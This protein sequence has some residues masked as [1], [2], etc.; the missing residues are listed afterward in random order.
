MQDKELLVSLLNAETEKDAIIALELQKLLSDPVLRKSRWK[1]LGGMPNNQSIVHAQQS[2]PVAA[3]V[4]KFTNAQDAL[5]LRYCKARGDDPRDPDAPSSMAHAIEQFLGT[6]AQSFASATNDSKAAGILRQYAEDNIVLYA[7]GTKTRPSLSLYDA[8][9]GQLATDFPQTF[10]SLIHG[11]GGGSYK[12]AIPFVQGRFN[13]GSSGVLPFCSEKY[14]MQLIVSRVPSDLVGSDTHEWA[15]TVVCFFPSN[16]DPSWHYLVGEDGQILTAGKDPLGLLPRA[17]AKSGEVSLPREKEVSFGTLVKMYDFK[18]PRSNICGEL[19]RKVE[20]FLLRPPLPLR[21]IE[22]RDQYK[23]NVMRVTVWDRLGAWA[24]DK[25]EPGFEDGASVSVQLETGESI[26]VEIRIFKALKKDGKMVNTDRDHPQTGLRAIINGQSHAKRDA[27]F[28][29]TKAVDKEHIAGSMLVLLDCT[30]LGQGSRNALFMS[31]RE[32]FRE[33]P[34]LADLFKKVQRELKNHE[35]LIELNNRR[36]EEKVQDAVNDEDG[37]KALEELLETVPDLA[38]LFGSTFAGSA[39]AQMAKGVAGKQLL[40]KPLKFEGTDL[41]TFFHRSDGSSELNAELP[42]GSVGTLS[43]QTDVKNN[44]FNRQKHRGKQIFSGDIVPST[45][46]FNGR[47]TLTY[48]IEKNLTVGETK[49]SKIQI[50]DNTGSGPF[51]LTVNITVVQPVEKKKK[52][53]KVPPKPKARTGPSKL[54]ISEV[55]NGEEANPLTIEPVPES[56]RLKLLLNVDSNLLTHALELRPKEESAAVN[57]VFK[58]GLALTALS[59]VDHAKRSEDW[60]ENQ[61]KSREGIESTVAGIARVI[62]PLCLS[63]PKKLPKQK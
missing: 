28:F 15:F 20:E 21:I 23:A 2:S 13:M 31:N 42:K 43:F 48:A 5:L 60:K 46:L 10:C 22:C 11:A 19:F 14:K 47:Y 53:P 36:Y 34:L 1:Y 26:P 9:E 51:E 3:L 17:G 12:G 32:T 41:P 37:L 63:L 45:R 35:G 16:Q 6:T 62:V 24:K 61:S 58:Y 27:Q 39:A 7:T 44:Y 18:A 52:S 33:D 8:G 57:F 56:E 55:K 38:D 54:D 49:T 50:S 40:V 59:L 29:R 25:L 4:E 30:N